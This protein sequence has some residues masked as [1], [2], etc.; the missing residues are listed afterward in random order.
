MVLWNPQIE[1]WTPLTNKISLHIFTK[2]KKKKIN[3]Y[4]DMSIGIT[5]ISLE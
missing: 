5:W 2:S 4:E 3:T 1:A